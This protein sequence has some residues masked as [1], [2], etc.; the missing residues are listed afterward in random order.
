MLV[1][2]PQS[3][4]GRSGFQ[5]SIIV[6]TLARPPLELFSLRQF[7]HLDINW[8]GFEVA[9]LHSFF[10]TLMMCFT[11]PTYRKVIL[12]SFFLIKKKFGAIICESI[13]SRSG[14]TTINVA[15]NNNF[16]E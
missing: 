1:L 6:C 4:E 12:E 5:S 15:P 8:L 7:L 10:N 14:T 11:I 16:I 9:S 13:S 2:S 3:G